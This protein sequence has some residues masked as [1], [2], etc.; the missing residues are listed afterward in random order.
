MITNIVSVGC[1]WVAHPYDWEE[2][3]RLDKI[4][5][6]IN[7]CRTF[8]EHQLKKYSFAH[9]L[10]EKTKLP[11]LNIASPGSSNDWCFNRLFT[12]INRKKLKNSIVFF[13]LTDPARYHLGDKGFKPV[14]TGDGL[15]EWKKAFFNNFYSE[16]YRI[17]YIVMMLDL[18]DEYLKNKNSK[19]VAFNSFSQSVS[20]P[21]R[22]YFFHKFKTWEDFI[23]SYDSRYKR[24]THPIEYDHKKLANIFFKEYFNG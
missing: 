9:F 22:N 10:S 20:Y 19:L 17:N 13:G 8:R 11:Y 24:V 15:Y 14:D 3:Y 1:S 6:S 7:S 21:E 12:T 18:F 4:N 16:S 2:K 23:M 5:P